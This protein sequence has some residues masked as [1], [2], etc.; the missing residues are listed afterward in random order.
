MIHKAG[1]KTQISQLY[2]ADDPNLETDVQIGV[3]A[4]LIGHYE[5]HDQ[6]SELAPDADA[7]AD[8]KGWWYLLQHRLV[9]MRGEAMVPAAPIAGKV[10]GERAGLVVLQVQNG[11]RAPDGGTPFRE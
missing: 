9:V 10:E 6:A 1:Y 4:A 11:S 3:T 8:V 5:A 7:D 2:S